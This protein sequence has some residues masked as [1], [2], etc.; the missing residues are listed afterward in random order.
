M[1]PARDTLQHV[2]RACWK[3]AWQ[4][5]GK[6][7]PVFLFVNEHNNIHNNTNM[8]PQAKK[9]VIPEEKQQLVE[10]KDA[11]NIRKVLFK[12]FIQWFWEL[13]LCSYKYRVVLFW[14]AFLLSV[15]FCCCWSTLKWKS[16]NITKHLMSGPWGNQLVLF[17][18]ECCC[19][20][21]LRLWNHQ[22]S[23]EN[24]TNCFPRDLTLSVY[25]TMPS[26]YGRC[27]RQFKIGS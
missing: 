20:P 9:Q 15:F 2:I 26:I 14:F 3:V 22:D 24:K 7:L 21:R 25:Y 10:E 5:A 11:D 1:Y 17:S 19:F 8:K 4:K 6:T 27:T 13:N 16:R 12:S 23:W 18:L